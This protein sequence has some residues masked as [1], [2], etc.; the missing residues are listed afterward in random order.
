MNLKQKLQL[1]LLIAM[2]SKNKNT[3]KAIRNIKTEI[4]NKEKSKNGKTLNDVDIISLIK[5]Y[6]KKRKENAI[7]YKN[8]NRMDLHEEEINEV[9]ILSVYLPTEMTV[10]EL[11]NKIKII[12][13]EMK[14]TTMKDM[15]KVI[16]KSM[17]EYSQF[18]DGKTISNIVKEL[19][20]NKN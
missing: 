17:K 5:S 8:N 9:S 10:V 16:G 12:I 6:I 2:K 3:I 13:E 19:L 20:T 1:D 15:G 11:T 4:S 7:L 18:S 14:A